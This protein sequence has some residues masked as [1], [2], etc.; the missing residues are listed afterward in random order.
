MCCFQSMAE[1][2][3]RFG[4]GTVQRESTGIVIYF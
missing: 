2:G 1:L 4:G 3:F